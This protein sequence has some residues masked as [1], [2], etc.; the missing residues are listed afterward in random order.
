MNNI[1]DIDL[2][3]F[4]EDVSELA[5]I[6]QRP[7]LLN[8]NP[9]NA[10]RVREFLENKCMLS[11]KS[12]IPGRIFPTHDCALVFWAQLI[13]ENRLK[14]PFHVTHIDAHS[15][16]GIGA[17]GPGYV[18]NSVL[19]RPPKMRADLKDP[20][21]L[22]KYYQ[23][24]KLDEA[25]YLLFALAFQWIESL[26]NVRSPKSKPDMP[27]QLLQSGPDEIAPYI[28]LP[29]PFPELFNAKYGEEPRILYREF[30][31]YSLFKTESAYD[32]ASLAI[33]PR[34]TPAEADF[35]IPIIS[36]YFLPI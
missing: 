22:N 21:A 9:W 35:L 6:G 24:Q 36:E 30:N 28:Q 33:S 23:A 12:P 16:L 17:P 5:D 25:N 29:Q 3:F 2:D 4:L 18:L 34:Y 11:S 15:D 13:I 7:V 10:E 19:C 27:R 31:D 8:Q 14:K 20:N 32:F 1:L 26:D